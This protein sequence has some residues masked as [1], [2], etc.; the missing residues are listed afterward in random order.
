MNKD[1][2]IQSVGLTSGSRICWLVAWFA[3]VVLWLGTAL[4]YPF[5][6]DLVPQNF[7]ADGSFR[8]ESPRWQIWL[9]PIFAALLHWMMN[10]AS[11]RP[12]GKNNIAHIDEKTPE[13]VKIRVQQL[14]RGMCWY[15]TALINTYF[16]WAQSIYIGAATGWWPRMPSLTLWMVLLLSIGMIYYFAKILQASQEKSV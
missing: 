15:L 1:S 4:A 8:G 11:K 13:H 5:L 16:A 6:P 10:W 9:L 12:V 14:N 3:L 7:H 2:T